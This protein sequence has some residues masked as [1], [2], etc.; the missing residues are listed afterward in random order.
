MGS[1]PEIKAGRVGG[2]P[3]PGQG[4]PPPAQADG[5]GVATALNDGGQEVRSC[6]EHTGKGE[7]PRWTQAPPSPHLALYGRAETPE[8]SGRLWMLRAFPVAQSPGAAAK[9]QRS[10]SAISW[11]LPGV[12][13]TP[14]QPQAPGSRGWGQRRG[15]AQRAR[16]PFTVPFSACYYGKPQTYSKVARIVVTKSQIPITLL[17]QI[18]PF[19][20]LPLPNY[21]KANSKQHIISPLSVFLCLSK[22]IKYFN[23]VTAIPLSHKK[24]I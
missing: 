22:I 8:A 9:K 17:P 10:G 5:P 11:P 16:P 18:L 23:N 14:T 3:R 20:H 15:C 7:N 12:Q 19:F 21:L 4:P 24:V 13:L 1:G 6:W 2:D